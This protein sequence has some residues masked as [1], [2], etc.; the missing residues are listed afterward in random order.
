MYYLCRFSYTDLYSASFIE[1]SE[2][3]TV[4]GEYCP[5]P[6]LTDFKL[7]KSSRLANWIN[8]DSANIWSNFIDHYDD[9]IKK[10]RKYY[11][12]KEYFFKEFGGCEDFTGI[13]FKE[14]MYYVNFLI[15]FG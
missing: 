7:P 2:D 4:F 12:E 8:D 13:F 5:M 6:N 3:V 1:P 15:R 9:E 14:E 10:T 11:G